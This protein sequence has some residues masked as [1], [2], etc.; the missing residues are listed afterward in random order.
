MRVAFFRRSPSFY[1]CLFITIAFTTALSV[2]SQSKNLSTSAVKSSAS[3]LSTSPDLSESI[4]PTKVSSF[5]DEEL[6]ETFDKM[7]S[8]YSKNAVLYNNLGAAFFERKMPE[9]AEAAIRRAIVLNN[10]PAFLTNLSIIYDS[11]KRY[12]EALSAAQRAVTQ[13]PKYARGRSQLCELLVVTK[14]NSDALI[15]YDELSKISSIDPENQALY[16]LALL[17]T[18]SPDRAISMVSPLIRAGNPTPLMFNVLGF[19]YFQKKRYTQ[20]SEAF[21]QGVELDPASGNL[22]YN[23]AMSLTASNNRVGAMSQYNMMK[24]KNPALADQL[25]R[26]LYRDKIIYVD[27]AVSTKSP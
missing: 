7:Q 9:K 1:T 22:R 26:F 24:E 11:Q 17:R 15:C 21:K 19:A 12:S 14:R 20:A 27:S 2:R 25:Y 13:A 23:L 10:H 3:I 5:S 18:G 4:D 16:A 8:R 6:T